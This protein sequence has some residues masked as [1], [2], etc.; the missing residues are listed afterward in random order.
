MD[1]LNYHHL[2]YFYVTA[3]EGSIVKAA[4][5]LHISQP[6]ISGQIKELETVLGE[7]LF[8]RV[9]RRLKLTE[10]GQLVYSYAAEI[11]TLGRELTDAVKKRP[12]GRPM[13]INVGVTDSIPKLIAYHL[14]LPGVKDANRMH[15]S[16]VEGPFDTLL[17]ELAAYK[18]DVVLADAP[19]GPASNIKG[20][21]HP[22]GESPLVVVGHQN[23]VQKYGT[24]FPQC[25][26]GAPV[27]MPSERHQIRRPLQAWFEA[28]KL[29]PNIVAEFTDSALLKTFGQAGHGFFFVPKQV[30]QNLLEQRNCTVLGQIDS[31]RERYFAIT[32]E[33]KIKHPA[34]MDI[35]QQAR[36]E[37][38]K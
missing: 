3:R 4:E 1:W 32:I 6:T 2:L 27:L 22:L 36:T 21:N 15:L 16:V 8:T 14:L 13:R 24:Q 37:F 35:C 7:A 11:F 19:L 34:V 23:L 25:L 17:N 26:S 31:I 12:S 38:F 9:G 29:V 33:R 28:N 10:M 18:L 30:T 20:Y 5:S